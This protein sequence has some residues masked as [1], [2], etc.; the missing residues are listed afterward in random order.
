MASVHVRT[1][2]FPALRPMRRNCICVC[3]TQVRAPITT[4][5]RGMDCPTCGRVILFEEQFDP[6]TGEPDE[7]RIQETSD[8]AE[9]DFNTKEVT[10]QERIALLP[11]WFRLSVIFLPL[12]LALALLWPFAASSLGLPNGWPKFNSKSAKPK[13]LITQAA[14]DW[15]KASAWNT[16]IDP[17]NGSYNGSRIAKEFVKLASASQYN[18]MEPLF[19]YEQIAQQAQIA[20][21]ELDPSRSSSEEYLQRQLKELLAGFLSDTQRITPGY[22][23]FRVIGTSSQGN[24]T[25][26]LIRYYRENST[27]ADMLDSEDLVLPLTKMVDFD[28]FQLYCDNL[29]RTVVS[30]P[31][32]NSKLQG[33]MYTNFFADRAF[34]YLVLMVAGKGSNMA[35]EDIFD[36]QI[37]RPLSQLCLAWIGASNVDFSKPPATPIT[38]PGPSEIDIKT[39]QN[40]VRTRGDK[41]RQVDSKRIR[42]ALDSMYEETKDPL[43][44]DLIGRLE[45]DGTN[46]E[47][48]MEMFRKAKSLRFQSLESHKYFILE[49]ILSGDKETL[50]QKLHDLNNYWD[51]KLTGL[52]AQE[53]RKKY[54]KFR[55]YWRR[56]QDL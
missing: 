14:F 26:V 17:I 27:P 55:T 19:D 54:H 56:G 7:P 52:D 46:Q 6:S 47:S 39:I 42:Q 13:T 45:I 50:I 36:F 53:D 3:G 21:K 30:E 12:L 48:G 44:L 22:H 49:S 24:R 10:L 1:G 11:K 20:I 9:L 40:W 41:F 15:P 23:D 43:M 32:K 35:I 38:L 16:S 34:G 8:Q 29:F 4:L 18:S 51:V 25:A 2:S 28:N 31:I 33:Y 37:Q 5:K